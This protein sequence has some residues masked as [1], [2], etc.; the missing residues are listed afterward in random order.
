MKKFLSLIVIVWSVLGT[1]HSIAGELSDEYVENIVRRSYQYVAMYNTNNNFAMQNENP[2]ST[3]GWNKMYVPSGLMD[4]TVTAIARPNNDT[5]YLISMLDMRDDAVVI[6]FPAFDSKFVSLETSAYDHYVNI[7]LSTT[8]GDFRKPTTMLFYTDRTSGY[9]GEPVEGI[10][11]TLKMT[12]DFATAFLRVAP[13]ASDSER[14][15][16]NL[17]AM[18]KQKLM[19]LSEFQG[20]AKKAVSDV[21]FPAFGNDKIVFKNN[22]L[23]VMQFVFNHTTFDPNDEMDQKA[24]STL[25]PLGVEP[26][27]EF[28]PKKVAQIN[29][30]KFA[31]IAEQVSAE[32]LRIWNDPKGNPY[33]TKAF[34]PKGKMTIEVMVL[35]SCVGPI[36]QPYDQA[37][38]PGI[39]T[40]DGKPMNAKGHYIIHMT[41]EQLPPVKAFWSATLYDAEKGLFIP[42]EYNKY[43]V[44][45]NGG[46]KLDD[47]GGIE[48][49][50]APTK[51]VDVAKENW[52]PSGEKDQQLDVMVRVYNP[53]IDAMKSWIPPKAENL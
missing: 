5:L 43:S 41:K 25:K 4:A 32:S 35:Q 10:D 53:D 20:K 31:K 30:E 9:K 22:F 28:D 7:P 47:M 15:Q 45:E 11:K 17:A 33:L 46:M 23:E 36:G 1:G 44:G 40:T 6:Q 49:H 42:N 24:L 52:L 50:I 27:K 37:Q 8:K 2:F 48:I 13:H 26:G 51:P 12:G 21:S 38:Y 18:H 29:G 16:R 19:T 34:Q 39:S 14:M 3:H